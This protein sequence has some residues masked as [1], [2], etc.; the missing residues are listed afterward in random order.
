MRCGAHS[1]KSDESPAN[2]AFPLIADVLRVAPPPC[3]QISTCQGMRQ[4][5]SQGNAKV[6]KMYNWQHRSF[7]W[8]L[9][10]VYT[11]F[12][13]ISALEAGRW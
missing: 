4:Q 7:A 5:R 6:L 9:T 2:R 12:S 13:G 3:I 11:F 10:T 1:G 8:Q